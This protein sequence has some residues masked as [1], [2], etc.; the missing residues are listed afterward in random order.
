M[1]FRLDKLLVQADYMHM[2]PKN[3]IELP[4]KDL[5][6]PAVYL[7][8]LG[9]CCMYIGSTKVGGT[10]YL[11]KGHHA[12]GSLLHNKNVKL[13]IITCWDERDA[14]KREM[15]LIKELKPRLN[16]RGS[17]SY[18]VSTETSTE[19]STETPTPEIKKIERKKR[20]FE[21]LPSKV[22]D[23]LNSSLSDDEK[24][25]RLQELSVKTYVRKDEL[26]F[27]KCKLPFSQ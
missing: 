10:R 11:F 5:L 7:F 4:L 22:K 19:I 18:V 25:S 26:I 21:T 6:S 27:T 3:A 13:F 12:I 17:S 9:D 8:Y 2:I 20:K 14:Y 16:V 23:L 1:L 15:E 24:L